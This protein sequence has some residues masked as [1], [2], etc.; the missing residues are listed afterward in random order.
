MLDGKQPTLQEYLGAG[1]EPLQ[2]PGW[3]NLLQCANLS[4]S[5]T[6]EDFYELL[7]KVASEDLF[8][9]E[10]K[11]HSKASA[12]VGRRCGQSS[13]NSRPKGSVRG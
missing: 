10:I 3:T 6:P 1:F 11:E 13:P 12:G 4:D 7:R 9:T 5:K 8:N 2:V